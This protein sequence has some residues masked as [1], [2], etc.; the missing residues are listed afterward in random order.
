MKYSVKLAAL[1]SASALVPAASAHAAEQQPAHQ[2]TSTSDENA[3]GDIV[4][5]AQKRSESAQRTALAIT[6]VGGEDL[7]SRQITTIAAIAQQVPN[8]NITEQIGQARI[9]MRGIGV[10]NI[11]TASEGSVAF[12]EDGVFY[13]RS[14]AALAS[15]YDL[16]R[17]EVLRG[18]QGTLYGRNATGGSVNL[19]T[20]KPDF[21]PTN[22]Y[23][24]LTGGNYNTL[25]T[26]AALGT[27]L[28]DT[29]AIR[30]AGQTQHHA[31][32]GHN[33][34]S[35][36]E[37]DGRDSQSLRGQILFKPDSN[38]KLLLGADYFQSDDTSNSY[39]YFGPGLEDA[40]GNVVQPVAIQIGGTA[41]PNIRDI[42]A[43]VDPHAKS[44]F[45]G[46]RADMSYE[47]SDAVT[48]RSISAYR[49]SR[50]ALD[51]DASPI[52]NV[53]IFPVFLGE[54]SNQFSQEFQFN[55]DTHRNKFVAG[56]YYLH[57]K[58]D[59]FISGPFNLSPGGTNFLAQGYYAG[60]TL[61]TNAFAI[62]AQDT[63]SLTDG[64]RVTLGARYSVE[65]KTVHDQADF[66]LARAYDPSNISL[67]P[68]FNDHKVFHSFTPKIGLEYDLT[69]T[70]LVYA[71]WSKGFKA[72]TYNLGSSLPSLRPEKVDAYTAGIKATTPDRKF[73]ANVEGFYYK[74]KDLQVGKVKQ[75]AIV[76]ENA[77]TATIYGLEG[78]FMA[79]PIDA[80]LTL[81]LNASWLHA[82]FDSYITPDAA[83]PSGDGVTIDPDTGAPAYNLHGNTLVQ[84]PNYVINAGID[85]V[86]EAPIGDITLH[87]DSIWSDRVYFNSYNRPEV[88]QPAY[89][90]QNATISYSDKNKNWQ[91]TAY[92]R[93][94]A[95]KTIKAGAQVATPFVGAPIIGFLQPPRTYGMSLTYNF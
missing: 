61:K 60:G 53:P 10:D 22:G 33:L 71:S 46:F 69:P 18:P 89:N 44:K 40:N 34:Q 32:Y 15:F 2:Q 79:K 21:G 16:E 82:R 77:A 83:R 6:A 73:R 47:L 35:G 95:N 5:T 39:H 84:A 48:V 74:Y 70:M 49:Y 24:M 86:I 25:N 9:T 59:G 75:L 13:S 58:I 94:I 78:E 45:Y 27:A 91:L 76:L 3:I 72:G 64:F 17:V 68:F 62:F 28:S 38:F 30:L 42:R 85:Y 1:L 41:A 92:L 26:E 67:V 29:V 66:D 57:E 7:R 55:V 88:S 11:S 81:S 52:G 65:R 43:T 20:K 54:K 12:N 90:L 63:Y 51:T 37:I 31:G 14:S 23:V 8:L 50:Y 19:I 87:A 80:P 4:V 93:N 56:L 36:K